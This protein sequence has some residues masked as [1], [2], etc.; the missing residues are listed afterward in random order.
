[1]TNWISVK[2][3]LP[4]D[5][6]DVLAFTRGIIGVLTFISMPQVPNRGYWMEMDMELINTPTHWMPLPE[7]PKENE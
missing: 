3:K 5:G 2:D 4:R 7:P 6:E 1:M